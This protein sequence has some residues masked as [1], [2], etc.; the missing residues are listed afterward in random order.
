MMTSNDVPENS[1]LTKTQSDWIKNNL[2][3]FKTTEDSFSR[4]VGYV[5]DV[6]QYFEDL[7]PYNP[8]RL[9]ISYYF[10]ILKE[11]SHIWDPYFDDKD[12]AK[13]NFFIEVNKDLM[14]VHEEP[15]TNTF[16]MRFFACGWV[17]KNYLE[18][19]KYLQN[20]M[21]TNPALKKAVSDALRAKGCNLAL[22]QLIPTPFQRLI[23]YSLFSK[24]WV[25]KVTN[26]ADTDPM[27]IGVLNLNAKFCLMATSSNQIAKAAET[28]KKLKQEGLQ[29]DDLLNS[30]FIQTTFR[31][32]VEYNPYHDPDVMDGIPPLNEIPERSVFL[33]DFERSRFMQEPNQDF[34]SELPEDE[35]VEEKTLDDLVKDMIELRYILIEDAFNEISADLK[36]IT[37]HDPSFF[38]TSPEQFSNAISKEKEWIAN[39]TDEHFYL[40]LE[41]IELVHRFILTHSDQDKK[42]LLKEISQ[43][44]SSLIEVKPG[45]VT[46]Y[47]MT[48]LACL[49]IASV[50]LNPTFFIVHGAI[51]L[52]ILLPGSVFASVGLAS[53]ISG[54]VEA[55]Q[56]F[57]PSKVGFFAV[58]HAAKQVTK[59]DM[60]E[61]REVT[62]D[63]FPE[64]AQSADDAMSISSSS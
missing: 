54:F 53:M 48:L 7:D 42:A 22:E 20:A 9:K 3:E 28:Q 10:Q 11:T 38:I 15:E 52:S 4:Q 18:I 45:R 60:D 19:S 51:S 25:E 47:V 13:P 36:K 55:K 1:M 30:I 17:L 56:T 27:K 40:L 37:N 50:F 58:T 8:L 32:A 21:N 2:N 46:A 29:Q 39:C 41:L 5:V 31:K 61:V 34:E 33:E 49:V 44:E 64:D 43:I 12:H 63:D 23:R 14:H 57:F 59:I 16:L 26:L 6:L 35:V 24:G 62:P